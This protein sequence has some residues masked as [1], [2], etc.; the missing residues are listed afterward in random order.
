MDA[1]MIGLDALFP[2]LCFN[3]FFRKKLPVQTV[4]LGYALTIIRYRGPPF[5]S[6]DGIINLVYIAAT[7]LRLSE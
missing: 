1:R 3:P 5:L 2:F 4:L 6:S 7:V